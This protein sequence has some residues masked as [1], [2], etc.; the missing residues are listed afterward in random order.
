MGE[1]ANTARVMP[2]L[3]RSTGKPAD[4]ARANQLEAAYNA[5]A[6]ARLALRASRKRRKPTAVSE[7]K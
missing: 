2:V 3:D 1:R 5:E 6:P 7:G 4:L